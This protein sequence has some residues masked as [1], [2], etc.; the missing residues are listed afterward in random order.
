MYERERNS[1][2]RT[3]LFVGPHDPKKWGG[4]DRQTDSQ[5]DTVRRVRPMLADGRRRKGA[6]CWMGKKL[7]MMVPVPVGIL[8]FHIKL[9]PNVI[10]YTTCHNNLEKKRWWLLQLAILQYCT[11]S[12]HVWGERAGGG[13]GK[14]IKFD[15]RGGYS[16]IWIVFLLLLLHSN[17]EMRTYFAAMT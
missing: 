17:N 16:I 3:L 4:T 6:K 5:T 7:G 15:E 11:Q 9:T 1:G 8:R 10:A 2:T 14:E 12:S 13:S